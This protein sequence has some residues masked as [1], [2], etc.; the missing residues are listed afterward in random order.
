MNAAETCSA[1]GDRVIGG[2]NGRKFEHVTNAAE[3]CRRSCTG[4]MLT[5]IADADVWLLL[6]NN[7]NIQQQP[8]QQLQQQT[9]FTTLMTEWTKWT[10][11]ITNI[12]HSFVLPIQ[13]R[14][15][16]TNWWKG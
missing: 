4:D 11:F 5:G 10:K 6:H 16:Q 2:C 8:Q 3:V 7:N 14:G 13:I 15:G 12:D 9:H 1:H